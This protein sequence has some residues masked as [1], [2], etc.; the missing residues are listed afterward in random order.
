MPHKNPVDMLKGM[1][2]TLGQLK[3]PYFI[4]GGMAVVVWGRPRFTADV[5]I[6]VELS[7][8]S[9]PKLASALEQFCKMG[10][11]DRDAMKGALERNGEFNYIDA[12]S[13][14]KVDFWIAGNS[15]FDRE[16]MKRAVTRET[17]GTTMSFISPE[18]LLLSKLLWVKKGSYRSMDDVVTIL[19]TRKDSLDWGYISHW[20]LTLGVQEELQKAKIIEEALR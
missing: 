11:I 18:D 8:E 7:P 16:A 17:Y 19:Q 10:M 9:L 20:V 5:D 3:I 12:D 2:L 1:V 4:T 13:D 15:P 14:V 6:V